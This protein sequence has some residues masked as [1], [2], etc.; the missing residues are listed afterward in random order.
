MGGRSEKFA[1]WAKFLLTNKQVLSAAQTLLISSTVVVGVIAIYKTLYPLEWAGFKPDSNKSVTTK[2][3]INSKD[4][5][6]IKLTE[7]TEQFQSGKTFWDWLGL[8]GTL[9]IPIVLFQFQCREQR[10]SEERAALEREIAATHLREEALENYI[11]R[12]SELLLDKQ[13]KILTAEERDTVLDVAR[14]RTLSVLRRLERDGE[15]KGS[16]IRFLIDVELANELNLGGANLGGVNLVRAN[17]KTVKL[18]GANLKNANLSDANL[19]SANLRAVKLAGANLKDANLKAAKLEG[20]FFDEE[21]IL[22]DGSKYQS[23][24]QLAKFTNPDITS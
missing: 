10:R 3:T 1:N 4:G 7:T 22:P 21:T 2:E 14:A 11:T 15:R 13:L 9:A 24:D 17:L 5:K 23:L 8:A 16:V 19:E 6:I 12:M 20:S 18:A